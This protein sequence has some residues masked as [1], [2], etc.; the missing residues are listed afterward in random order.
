M[1]LRFNK[2]IEQLLLQITVNQLRTQV[3]QQ[4]AEL[5]E[6]KRKLNAD[7]T[8]DAETTEDIAGLQHLVNNLQVDIN[9]ANNAINLLVAHL[10]TSDEQVN[11]NFAELENRINN[12][13]ANLNIADSKID[14]LIDT[15]S[16]L[17]QG[18]SQGSNT[19]P[20]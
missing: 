11:A 15:L 4:E 8:G 17:F 3:A 13:E 9:S 10:N 5:T 2:Q 1:L 19:L 18:L 16:A 6:V 12:L 14:D 7:D 20:E